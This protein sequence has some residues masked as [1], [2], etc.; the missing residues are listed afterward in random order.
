[1]EDNTDSSE[2]SDALSSFSSF[3]SDEQPSPV[4]RTK[5][6]KATPSVKRKTLKPKCL[7][8]GKSKSKKLSSVEILDICDKLKN[9]DDRLMSKTRDKVLSSYGQDIHGLQPALNGPHFCKVHKLIV[10]DF[11]CLY[12]ENA[13]VSGKYESFQIAMFSR[14]ADYLHLSGEKQNAV[15]DAFKDCEIERVFPVLYHAVVDSCQ[16]LIVEILDEKTNSVDHKELVEEEESELY[17]MHG[18]VLYELETKK[19]IQ[20]N[21]D[22]I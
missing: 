1:M 16:G 2:S 6:T 18:W 21:G 5:D 11:V 20:R 22:N 13:T 12:K 15:K 14:L 7:G 8:K 9:V 3:S 10:E 19:P 17:R 4:K